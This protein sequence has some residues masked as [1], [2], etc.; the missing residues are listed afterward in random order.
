MPENNTPAVLSLKFLEIETPKY[1]RVPSKPFIPLGYDDQWAETL[2]RLRK[3]SAK[4]NAIINGKVKYIYGQGVCMENPCT[5]GEIFTQTVNSKGES[6]ADL[7]RR[8]IDDG[9]TFGGFYWHIITDRLGRITDILHLEW[10]KV[11]RA[12]DLQR[13]YFKYDWKD[14]KEKPK[15]FLAYNATAEGAQSGVYYFDE[16]RPGC[17]YY[18][19]PSY[20]GAV[21]WI[22]A[23]CELGKHTY[24][25]SK[26]GFS[27][28][29]MLNFFNGEPEERAK[30]KLEERIHEKY[31]GEDGKKI[32]ITFNQDP[33]KAPTILDLGASDLTKEDFSAVNNLICDNIYAGHEITS[34]ILFGIKEAGQLG[35]T[36]ELRN[37]FDIF[38]N[39]YASAKRAQYEEVLNKFAKLKGIPTKFYIKPVEPVGI[40]LT[41]D[42]LKEILTKEELRVRAGVPAIVEEQVGNQALNN[43]INRL[44]PLVANKVIEFMTPNEI[45]SIAGLPAKIEGDSISTAPAPVA[46]EGMGTD[47]K[48]NDHL[49]NLTGRQRANMDRII[50]KY[51]RGEYTRERA[52]WELKTSL[53]ISDEDVSA[54]LGPA[55]FASV[56]YTEEQVAEMFAECGTDAEGFDVLRS[57]SFEDVSEYDLDMMEMSMRLSF[58]EERDNEGTV[59]DSKTEKAKPRKIKLPELMVL[60]TYEKKTKAKG[61]SVIPTTRPFCRKLVGLARFYTRKEIQTISQRLGYDVFNRAGG[62]W[63]NKGVIS[64]SC[65]HYWKMN[66]VVKK[67]NK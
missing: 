23:D 31:T 56:E 24:T 5:E 33:T 67:N 19:E 40:E 51:D 35:G 42:I 11:R 4:H 29:K 63:N 60:Y 66:L 62:F 30:R 47:I 22:A 37:A 14:T 57:E 52:A 16:Y 44:S 10:A 27:A 17:P 53:G 28:S 9:E 48:V 46:P 55:Q 49:K 32:F 7:L 34:P 18:P 21:N 43:A 20:L 41:P 8:S 25:N 38:N 1:K 61:P 13:F 50:R 59:N 64:K 45:R 12:S 2:L 58:A 6:L 65:R 15:E 36:T 3:Q 54:V 39:T 26:A